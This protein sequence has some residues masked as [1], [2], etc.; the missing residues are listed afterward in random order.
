MRP[1]EKESPKKGSQRGS[2]RGVEVGQSYGNREAMRVA[3]VHRATQ[4]GIYGADKVG[5]ALS[6]FC[7]GGYAGNEDMWVAFYNNN[8]KI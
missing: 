5:G 8:K 3:G 6:I 7:S 4:G 2:I 1:S